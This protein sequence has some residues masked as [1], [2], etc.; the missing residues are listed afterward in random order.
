MRGKTRPSGRLRAGKKGGMLLSVPKPSK[1]VP[2]LPPPGAP[3][4]AW[5]AAVRAAGLP[6]LVERVCLALLDIPRG[7][8]VSYGELARR[9]GCR[10]PRAVGQALKRNPFAPAVPCHRVVASDG[11]IGGYAGHR[12]GEAV[13][14]KRR[15][16]EEEGVLFTPD[17]RVLRRRGN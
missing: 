12:D 11:R 2:S 1:V 7:E 16:L 10:S 5:K 9:V 3:A 17:G 8:V 6:P 14:R 4:A 13:R 15:L